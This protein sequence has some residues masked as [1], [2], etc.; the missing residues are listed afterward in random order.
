[1]NAQDLWSGVDLKLE[2]SRFHLE[3]MA[4]SILPPTMTGNMAAQIASSAMI[5][6]NWQRAFYAHLDGF[7]SA[8]KSIGDVVNCCFGHDTSYRMRAFF[9]G[10]DID[11]QDR[12]KEF[13]RQFR[14][15]FDAFR[16]LAMSDAR[17]VTE[18]RTGYPDVEVTITGFSGVT[19][20]GSPVNPVPSSETPGN[21]LGNG[22][23]TP[24][25]PSVSIP[26][27]PRHSD[28]TIDGAPLFGAAEDYLSQAQQ[29]VDTAR[30]IVA[31]VHNNKKL[32][33]PT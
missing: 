13:S 9:D 15:H 18:H 32:T 5:G 7:L 30:K 17:H 4:T 27:Y 6:V 14:P 10:L 29:L 33:A 16:A 21:N 24:F 11:E 25:V 12:R 19:H 26:L 22:T 20:I 23:T 3:K 2:I 31:A 8:T 28:F 1:M